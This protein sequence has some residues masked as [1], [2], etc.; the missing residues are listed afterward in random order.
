MYLIDTSIFVFALRGHPRVAEQLSRHIAEPRALSVITYGELL[1]GALK[2]ARPVEAL[3]SVR[4]IA[5]LYPVID[6]SRAIVETF[7][8][9]RVQLER[10][11][12]RLEDFDIMIA[13]T[14]LNLGYTLVTDNTR[15]F[16]R[17]PGLRIENWRT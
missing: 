15:H 12:Q 17:I 10:E 6:V 13:A 14:A 1:C 9:L 3:A 2:C 8:L 11:G 7:S 4:R 5:E 16:D